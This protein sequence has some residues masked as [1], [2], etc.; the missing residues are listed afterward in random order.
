MR[1]S[2]STAWSMSAAAT[3]RAP[4]VST[5]PYSQ[6]VQEVINKTNNGGRW[7]LV[8]NGLSQT[9]VGVKINEQIAPN[10]YFIGDVDTG[11]DPYSLRFGDGPGSLVANNNTALA[12]QTPTRDF[13]R[14]GLDNTR[15]YVGLSNTTFGTLT[16]GR[17]YAFT[18]D[19]VGNLRSV[20]RRLRLLADRHLGDPRG[21]H[22]DTESARYNTSVKY[23]V[24]Y[25]GFRAG[26]L[27]TVG[28]WDQGNGAHSRLPVRPW[29][30][31]GGFSVD[32]IY[33]YAKDAVAL[34]PLRR[35]SP[36]PVATRSR[37]RSPTSTPASIAGKYKW[38]AFT[39]YGGYEY[40][41]LSSPSDLTARPTPQPRELQPL[42]A[43]YPGVVQANAYVNPEDL[44]VLGL[45]AKYAILSNLD[46]SPATIT[47]GRTTTQG[48]DHEL[49]AARRPARPAANSARAPPSSAC[50]G[51][52]EAVSGMLDW[53]PVKRVDV[54]SGV[55]FSKSPAGWPTAHQSDNTAFTSGVRVNF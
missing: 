25:N 13:S 34:R 23:L 44:Q 32:A 26:A 27:V 50:A 46:A 12:N 52:T 35:R 8:P 33:A 15:A 31:L 36:A 2:L 53:R 5:P 17:Q 48:R 47:S 42:N 30:R 7:Q 29:R 51:P 54:Y 22:G 6:G 4:S 19:A 14:A 18:N 41:R 49:R 9:N 55:M 11:F 3:R 38:Q 24:A 43:D 28:G 37:R 21:G 39:V 20:R 16:F 10:W 40:A 1:E 45:G